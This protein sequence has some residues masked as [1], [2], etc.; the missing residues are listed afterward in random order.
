MGRCPCNCQQKQSAATATT[1]DVAAATDGVAPAAI[2]RY[3]AAT[4]DAGDS[5]GAAHAAVAAAAV[6]VAFVAAGVVGAS[7]CAVAFATGAVSAENRNHFPAE[8][9]PWLLV[10]LPLKHSQN[11]HVNT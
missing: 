11:P 10:Q 6:G 7:D 3:A 5:D 4:A 8:T 1:A 9:L 2:P